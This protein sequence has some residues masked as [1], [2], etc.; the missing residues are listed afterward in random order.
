MQHDKAWDI[1]TACSAVAL[2]SVLSDCHALKALKE[3]I[4]SYPD[5]K[6]VINPIVTALKSAQCNMI[7]LLSLVR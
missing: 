7:Q 3:K 2:Q 6:I 1:K 4:M 5:L